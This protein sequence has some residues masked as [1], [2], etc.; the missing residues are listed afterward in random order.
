MRHDLPFNLNF[1]K[2]VLKIILL[3]SAVLFHLVVAQH[4]HGPPHYD[5]LEY[6]LRNHHTRHLKMSDQFSLSRGLHVEAGDALSN[7]D[8]VKFLLRDTSTK[9]AELWEDVKSELDLDRKHNKEV[10]S[11]IIE[12]LGKR[13]DILEKYLMSSL[14]HESPTNSPASTQTQPA[15]TCNLCD[16]RCFELSS[17]DEHV[18]TTHPSLLCEECGK[19]LRRKPDLNLHRHRHHNQITENPSQTNIHTT[20]SVQAVLSSSSSPP[21]LVQSCT[22]CGKTFP[23]EKELDA[24]IQKEHGD[25]SSMVS[26][27]QYPCHTHHSLSPQTSANSL[28]ESR[29]QSPRTYYCYICDLYR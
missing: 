12:G 21:N 24:H 7:A 5:H 29:Q 23:S 15:F 26:D 16:H 18:Q 8:V 11:Q 2:I 1:L 13:I 3:L 19:T 4:G 22:T 14:C 27:H 17:L 6:I 10:N 25:I 9:I 28:T 20:V